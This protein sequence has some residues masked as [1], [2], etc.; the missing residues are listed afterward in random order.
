VYA[1]AN[2]G[3]FFTA[4]DPVQKADAIFVLA[5]STMDRPLEAVDL[6][7]EGYAP[8]IV[9]TRETPEQGILI[10]AKRGVVLPFR[11]DE[12]RD[13]MIQLGVPMNAIVVPPRIHDN[14]AQ[15]AQTLR[16]LALEQHWRRVIVIAARYQ[17]RRARMAM[18][19]ELRDTGIDIDVRG[20]RYDVV[21][22]DRWWT[23]RSDWRWVLNEGAKLLAYELG[24]GA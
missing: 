16:A 22:P 4:D 8:R 18:R 9:L 12:A 10:S 7:L 6:Y 11:A 14:T 23:S 19:R 21:N 3:R 5:G 2:V 24:L 20:T 13:A 1:F 15:E 17:A